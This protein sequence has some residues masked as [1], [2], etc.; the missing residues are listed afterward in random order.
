MNYFD[1][2]RKN[3]QI[4]RKSCLDAARQVR[5][6]EISSIILEIHTFLNSNDIFLN[7]LFIE[8]NSLLNRLK[9]GTRL[10]FFCS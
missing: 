1:F 6:K 4:L 3:S 10:V 8:K 7:E 5:N 2:I 9:V